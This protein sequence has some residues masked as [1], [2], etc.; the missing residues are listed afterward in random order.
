MEWYVAVINVR[1][2]TVLVYGDIVG[3]IVVRRKTKGAIMLSWVIT[4]QTRM[5]VER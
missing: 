2:N 5:L 4:C 1:A 3:G